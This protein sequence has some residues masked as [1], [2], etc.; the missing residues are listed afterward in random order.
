[1]EKPFTLAFGHEAVI[2][3]VFGVNTLRVSGYDADAN[4]ERLMVDLD[5]LDNMRDEDQVRVTTRL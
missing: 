3:D 5:L 2:P 1:M 4:D